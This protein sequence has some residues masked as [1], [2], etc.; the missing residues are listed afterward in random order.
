M[1]NIYMEGWSFLPI[2]YICKNRKSQQD[3]GHIGEKGR[4]RSNR[5]RGVLVLPSAIQTVKHICIP[6]FSGGDF[7][8]RL[9]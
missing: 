8:L 5:G 7:Y 2:I 1:E 9:G 3:Q 6:G 4:N